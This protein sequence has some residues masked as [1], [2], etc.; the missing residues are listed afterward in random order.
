MNI[1]LA[2]QLK[3]LRK[4]KNI[5]QEKLAQYLN[6][7]YQAV[8]KW[9]NGNTYP[10]IGLLPDIARFFGVTIDELLQ[11]EKLN[12]EKLF[13]EYRDKA[14]Q[15]FRNGK[16]EEALTVWQEAYRE[17]PNNLEV[18]EFLMSSYFDTDKVKYNREIIE[19][20]MEIYGSD[21][22]MYYKG[23]AIRELAHTYAELGE[24]EKA[25]K[26]ALKTAQVNH[27]QEVLFSEIMEGDEMVAQVSFFT[28]WV[29]KEMLYMA[30]RIAF[31]EDEETTLTPKERQEALKTVAKLMQ[32]V[33]RDDDM[34]FEL[35]QMLYL[36]HMQIVEKELALDNEESIVQEHL[37]RAFACVAKS[38][39]MKEHKL[40]HPMLWGWEVQAAPEGKLRSVKWMQKELGKE[41]F[42][43]YKSSAWFA[44]L[45][46]KLESLVEV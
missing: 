5:S 35:L 36:T 41:S 10:D 43:D 7:S 24:M 13:E 28:Y 2:E 16:V 44:E 34:S 33:Y 14:E 30:R 42:A 8:S 45:E 26:W 18:K 29:L 4:E 39:S 11:V 1:N 17:M 9:E 21:A 19:L 22:S 15:F 20:G 46:K 31:L 6:V 27:S 38:V 23:Q 3:T 40:T 32:V 25:K 37:Q 12:E